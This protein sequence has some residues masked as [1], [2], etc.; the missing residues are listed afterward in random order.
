MRMKLRTWARFCSSWVWGGRCRR[1]DVSGDAVT[2]PAT[3][4]FQR[5]CV[6]LCCCATGLVTMLFPF[7]A[8]DDLCS[9]RLGA[10]LLCSNG[11]DLFCSSIHAPKHSPPTNCA[12]SA[13]S[14]RET[15]TELI[16]VNEQTCCSLVSDGHSAVGARGSP[17]LVAFQEWSSPR[18]TV[19]V[20]HKT[21]ARRANIL[22][23]VNDVVDASYSARKKL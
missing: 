23:L 1:S 12:L 21:P 8:Q 18:K 4:L 5:W 7:C 14:L 3:G 13:V 11:R 15:L 2:T 10:L 19:V 16:W 17:H 6:I 9:R 20:G 22:A